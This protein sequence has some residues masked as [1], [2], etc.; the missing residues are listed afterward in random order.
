MTIENV[1]TIIGRAM[2]EPEYRE[3]LFSDPDK[4]LD[5]YD[6]TQEEIQALK[7]LEND[8][9]ELVG[10]ELEERVSR[11]GLLLNDINFKYDVW[12]SS[13]KH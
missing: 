5:G 10:N 12:G 9:V 4:A 11:M 3:L 6:L 2:V 13:F 7:S 8:K 1:Q